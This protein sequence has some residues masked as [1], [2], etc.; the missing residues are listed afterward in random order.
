MSTTEL[1]KVK[2]RPVTLTEHEVID[3]ANT[4]YPD[5]C[6]GG[7]GGEVGPVD[8]LADAIYALRETEEYVVIGEDLYK[9]EEIEETDN[10]FFHET[11]INHNDG[12]SIDFTALYYNGGCHWTEL[13]EEDLNSND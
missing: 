5:F 11:R 13:L 6:Y 3:L 2:L 8:T 4:E 12:N 9:I 7:E 10:L 1:V